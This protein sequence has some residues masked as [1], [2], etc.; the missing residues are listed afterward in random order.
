M[1]IAPHLSGATGATTPGASASGTATERNGN[2]RRPWYRYA[3]PLAAVAAVMTGLVA[4]GVLE[5]DDSPSRNGAGS[6]TAETNPYDEAFGSFEPVTASGSGRGTIPLPAGARA[7]IITATYDGTGS[8]DVGWQQGMGTT[9]LLN[10]WGVVGPYQGGVPFGVFAGDS[11]AADSLTVFADE[12]PW[13]VTIAPVSSG[14]EMP[15]A[16]SGRNDAVFLH[17]GQGAEWVFNRT[18]ESRHLDVAQIV[19][20]ASPHTAGLLMQWTTD[21]ALERVRLR[22]GP[23]VVVVSSDGGWSATAR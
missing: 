10:Y 14:A 6:T 17:S 22:A 1:T 5:S 19:N 20:L 8:F 4:L 15:A 21:V 11:P 12:G 23:S 18:T 3:A 16:V 2:G 13:Q 7:G 9:L